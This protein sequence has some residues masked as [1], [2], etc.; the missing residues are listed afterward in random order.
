MYS[1]FLPY[2]ELYSAWTFDQDAEKGM[3]TTRPDL[4]TAMDKFGLQGSTPTNLVRNVAA[5]DESQLDAIEDRSKEKNALAKVPDANV[6]VEAKRKRHES[7]AVVQI[8]NCTI[9]GSLDHNR[10][11]CPHRTGLTE[12]QQR[13]IISAA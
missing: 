11:Q 12:A 5:A 10:I 6:P 1:I 2:E 3:L 8:H 13:A 4:K 7:Q 9:C